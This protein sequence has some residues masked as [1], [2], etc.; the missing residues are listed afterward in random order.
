[1]IRRNA[2]WASGVIMS[3]SSSITI[4][5]GG[6]SLIHGTEKQSQV[7]PGETRKQGWVAEGRQLPHNRKSA[8]SCFWV[9][10]AFGRVRPGI[11]LDLFTNHPDA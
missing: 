5:Q 10:L 6:I 8:P 11:L 4:F 1:M 9:Y 2:A 3:A 7:K